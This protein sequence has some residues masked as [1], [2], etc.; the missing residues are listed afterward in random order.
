M[1]SRAKLQTRLL[2]VTLPLTVGVVGAIALATYLV[3]RGTVLT[4]LERGVVKTSEI[5][6]TEARAAVEQSRGDAA[7]IA[8]SPLFRDHYQ[9]VEYG[10][11]QEAG[12]YRREI[13]RMLAA[14]VGRNPLYT[15]IVYADA[16]G[17]AVVR[18]E[19]GKPAKGGGLEKAIV[20]RLWLEKGIYVSDPVTRE[21]LEHPVLVLGQAIR[22]D[23]GAARG[24]LAFEYSLARLDALLDKLAIGR[25][26]SSRLVADG[27]E[28]WAG[29]RMVGDRV[30]ARVAVQGT[31]W[32]VVTSVDRAEFLGPLRWIG[33]ATLILGLLACLLITLAI[34][35]QV[36]VVVRPIA[37]LAKVAADYAAGNLKARVQVSGPQEV[38]VLSDAFN[39]MA[40]HLERRTEDLVNRV[41]ELTAVHRLNE[42]A[43]RNLGRQAVARA[44]L[45]AAIMGLGARRGALYRVDEEA[46]E[47]ILE[48]GGTADRHEYAGRRLPINTSST[49]VHA[50]SRGEVI[51]TAFEERLIPGAAGEVVCAPLRARG[52]PSHLLCLDLPDGGPERVRSFSLF[53]GAAGVALANAELLESTVAS[54]ARYR[55]AIENSPHAVVSL[56]QNYRVTLWNR[57]AEALFGW[58]PSEAFG[59]RLDFVLE[60]ADYDALVRTVETSGASREEPVKAFARDG[61]KLSVTVSWT[62]QAASERSGREWFVVI[63]DETEKRRLQAQLLHAEKLSA[64]G[65]LIAGI[66]HE[67]NNPLAAVVGFSEMLQDLPAT[68]PQKEDL[69]HLYGNALRCRDIV[70][71]LLSFV[72]RSTPRRVR[73]D[74]GELVERALE[75]V[76]YRLVRTDGVEL[77]VERGVT[78]LPVAV[79][80]G[81]LEQ[82]VV[83]LLANASDALRAWPRKRKITVRTK[84][85]KSGPVLEIEDTGPG[86]AGEHRERLFEPFFTTKP[87]GVGTGLGLAISSQIVAESGGSI[88]YEDAPGGG[89]RFVVGFP[90]CP[91]DVQLPTEQP[92]V[93]GR[94]PVKALLVDDEGAVLAL[95]RKLLEAEGDKV[96]CATSFEQAEAFVK[97]GK[98]DLVVVDA[99][100]GKRKG[101]E[102]LESITDYLPAVVV[103]TGDVLN[104]EL[105]ARFAGLDVPV[106]GKPFLRSDFLRAVRTALLS[107]I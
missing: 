78:P 30:V 61:R 34:A 38:A 69:K 64:V 20:E 58:Q 16:R 46:G 50:L 102:L 54:E 85:G 1:P 82:V 41:R 105:G 27:G 75:L 56:D 67:L 53:C 11:D 68:G 99:D 57:R 32:A 65:T 83:N 107:R 55:T 39:T 6:A 8:N 26:G 47:L 22:D 15:R 70:R 79:D 91:A 49:A 95:M 51:E 72:R 14:F 87:L 84:M 7:T 23:S 89:A 45:E 44:C 10:L 3:A 21:G 52:K 19:D 101:W 29:T 73:A 5:A 80:P 24:F 42:A 104:P 37:A 94:S 63:Q 17:K 103:V 40:Q 77:D 4:Q 92:V 98:F 71:G 76:E 33:T 66:A 90:S 36:R 100:L 18:V 60:K 25:K 12:V 9:N 86:V 96:S 2:A 28:A 13:E 88:S 74:L 31:R 106:L 59:R 62:G 43:L 35:G 97:A 48:A 81:R 93:P